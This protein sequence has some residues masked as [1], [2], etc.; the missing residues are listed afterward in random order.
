MGHSGGISVRKKGRRGEK[1]LNFS[2]GRGHSLGECEYGLRQAKN[3]GKG[4][5][6]RKLGCGDRGVR[7]GKSAISWGSRR[8][9]EKLK[10]ETPS[11]F[12]ACS[13]G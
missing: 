1:L 10:E 5:K 8:G 4:G 2:F 3:W 13:L 9:E 7:G 12:L 11:H 6:G